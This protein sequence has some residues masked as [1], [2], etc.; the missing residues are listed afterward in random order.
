MGHRPYPHRRTDAGDG[1]SKRADDA[2][3]RRLGKRRDPEYLLRNLERCGAEASALL[4]PPA[5]RLARWESD[6]T[7]RIPVVLADAIAALLFSLPRLG[8]T[9]RKKI[10]S[11]DIENRALR[12]LLD[13]RPVNALAREISQETGQPMT[14]IRRRLQE[15]KNSDQLK[16]L[17][18]IDPRAK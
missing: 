18:A 17:R 11:A 6:E 14:S 13:G 4:L 16:K 12:G 9:G 1:M 10:W 8:K 7:V 15:M 5:R 2:R 3:L